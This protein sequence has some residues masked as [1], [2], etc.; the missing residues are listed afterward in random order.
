MICPKRNLD[1]IYRD[2]LVAIAGVYLHLSHEKSW[3]SLPSVKAN[4]FTTVDLTPMQEGKNSIM[5]IE[6]DFC[7]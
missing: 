4:G 1:E 7:Y 6:T 5:W 2:E 3:D